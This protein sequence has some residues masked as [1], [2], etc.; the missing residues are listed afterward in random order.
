MENICHYVANGHSLIELCETYKLSF[1]SVIAWIR[2]DKDRST[3]YSKCIDD[4][5]EW[6]KERILLEL[7]RIGLSDLKKMHNKNG[8]IL[9]VQDWPDEISSIVKGIDYNDDGTVRKITIWNKE[10]CLELLGKT[11]QMFIDRVE[12]SG[13][14]TLEDLIADSRKPPEDEDV[15]EK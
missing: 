14:L 10:K 13:A 5:N 8:E 6:A 4:R 7:R 11:I 2:K 15:E 3:M 1:G 12:H 9:P